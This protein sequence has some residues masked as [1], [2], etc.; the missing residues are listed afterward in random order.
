MS[1]CDMVA[2]AL[3]YARRGWKVLPLTPNGKTP[4]ARLVPHGVKDATDDEA[5]IRSWFAAVPSAN[6]GI[7]TGVGDCGPY[8]VDVDSPNGG[9]KADGA[10]SLASAGIDMPQTLTATTPNGG[11]HYYFGLVEPPTAAQLKNCTNV[12]GLLG[13]DVR[14]VGGFVVAPPSE[15]DGK[16]Y[17]FLNWK[18]SHDLV[19][20]P[21]ELYLRKKQPVISEVNDRHMETPP[22]GAGR[23][24]AYERARMYLASCDAAISGQGGHNA[25]LHAA[26]ALVVGFA[27][28][29]VAALGL[30]MSDFNPR[31]VPPWTEKELRHKVESALANPQKPM[32]YLLAADSA[33]FKATP[34]PPPME[35]RAADQGGKIAPPP[36]GMSPLDGFA[37]R[38]ARRLSLADFPDPVPEDENPRAL[39]KGG[40]LRK[41]GGALFVSVSG[42]G[43][44]VAATQF[45][46]CFALGRPWFGIEPLRPLRLAVYQWE[47]D[48]DEV[49]DFRENIRRGLVGSGWS[50][51]ETARA[52]KAITYHDVTGLVGDS[53]LSYLAAAQR[54][55]KADLL[56]LNPLQSF[57]GCDLTK[58]NEL[59]E[60]LRAKLDP[61][62]RDASAPCGC[63][64]V[65]HTNKVPTNGKERHYWLEDN[66]AAYA[67]AGGAEL[68]NWAR[69]VL[70]LRPHEKATG[71]YD[72]LAAKR[73]KRLGWKDADGNST[74]VKTLAHTE[75]L[76]FWR[77]PEPDE[78]AAIGTA[79]QVCDDAKR[80]EVLELCRTY[81]KPFESGEALVAAIVARN[82]A[83]KTAAHY[84]VNG[85][86]KRG[87]L[88]RRKCET[89]NRFRIGT[90]E[91]MDTGAE[92]R[93]TIEGEDESD[94]YWNL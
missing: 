77:E 5:I 73:G 6:L 91:Q 59:S 32:G 72:L 15:L 93:Q 82:I 58:N 43:K 47:D 67:G 40:W 87:E 17:V 83:K 79:R 23:P 94:P 68:V 22:Q 64:I 46:A 86:V 69:A 71:Y 55:D 61:L 54:Q 36:P 10:A 11:K 80:G 62:L 66:S 49:A 50:A 76:M 30:L 74:I 65:H 16:P 21:S 42:A 63:L 81:G 37:A 88:V 41:G 70:T 92:E 2:S 9:H 1:D 3:R 33:D 75:G 31:C 25:T 19:Q 35:A 27:L 13:V 48:L 20:F 89:G 51:D 4:L 28:D 84:L 29:D 12:N 57:A 39:F 26:H 18:G 8:V 24:D 53:F 45:A 56:I 7:A 44:S 60:L 52:F 85:C 14:T 34:L 90:P 38:Y 78:L